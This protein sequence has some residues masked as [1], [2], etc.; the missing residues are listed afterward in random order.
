MI[1]GNP[2][3]PII[4]GDNIH[5]YYTGSETTHGVEMDKWVTR[6][7]RASWKRDRFVALGG[8]EGGAITTKPLIPPVGSNF[9]E[10]NGSAAG[11]RIAVELCGPGGTAL[12]GF[13]R[14]DCVPF[15]RDELR[16]KVKWSSGNFP[17]TEGPIQIRFY[18]DQAEVYSFTFCE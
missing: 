1:I 3:E 8:G 13:T 9:L 17:A 10:I 15:D 2:R 4:E 5:W 16:W 12:E 6:I 7:G 14:E 18:L 11:G